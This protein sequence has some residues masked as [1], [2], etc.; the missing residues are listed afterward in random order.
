MGQGI[1]TGI[2][3]LFHRKSHHEIRIYDRNVRSNIKVSQRIFHSGLIV[4]D[5][6][7]CRYLC[8]CTGCGRNRRESCF[9]S[10]FREAKRSDQVFKCSLRVLIERPHRLRR[11]DR[12]TAAHGY[13][14]VRLK[15]A[16]RFRASHNGLHRRIR[17]YALKNFNFHS[18]VF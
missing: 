15:L 8:S 17:F 9:L 14:P 2:G 7:E 18:T 3:N 4:C 6:R 11:I 10:Q 1:H 12:G 16:H 13:D 5:N